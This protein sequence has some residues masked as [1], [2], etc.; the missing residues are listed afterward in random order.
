[1]GGLATTNPGAAFA[2]RAPWRSWG[3][4]VR[5]SRFNGAERAITPK[6][7]QGLKLKWAFAVPTATGQ[8]SQPAVVR[9]TLYFGGTNGV[10]Y[11]LNATT[12]KRR[13]SFDTKPVVHAGATGNPLRDGPAVSGGIVYFGDKKGNV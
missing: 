7:V 4:D 8:Q 1:M 2:R 10:F 3:F 12:G 13:W 6:N 9:N 11:A 5:G